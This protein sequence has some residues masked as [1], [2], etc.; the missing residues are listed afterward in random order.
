MSYAAAEI[1]FINRQDGKESAY[2]Y[3]VTRVVLRERNDPSIARTFIANDEGRWEEE[4]KNM[5]DLCG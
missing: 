5:E 3:P 4:S 1:T 2:A